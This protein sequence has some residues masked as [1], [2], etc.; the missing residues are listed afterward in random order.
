MDVFILLRR[1]TVSMRQIKYTQQVGG[2]RYVRVG[3]K[4]VTLT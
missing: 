1:A 4:R 2:A 3:A